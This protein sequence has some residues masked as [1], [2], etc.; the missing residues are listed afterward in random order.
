[1]HHIVLD[2][3][4]KVFTCLNEEGNLKKV[5]GIPR[6]VTIREVSTL[7][8]KKSF[9]KGCQLFAAHMEEAPKDKVSNI[10]DSEVLR[11]FKYVFIEILRFPPKRDIDFSINIIPRA[12]PVSKNP[13]RMMLA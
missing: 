3:Y 9:R 13:Y 2:C 8:L 11:E 6:V 4:N 7:Q 5:Q 1:M 12:S 10:E